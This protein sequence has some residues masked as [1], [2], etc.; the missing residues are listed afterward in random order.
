MWPVL[1]CIDE[2][3]HPASSKFQCRGASGDGHA[4]NE[5]AKMAFQ[6]KSAEVLFGNVDAWPQAG[7]NTADARL[8]AANIRHFGCIFAAAST[9]AFGVAQDPSAATLPRQ[10]WKLLSRFT[11]AG[12]VRKRQRHLGRPI[13]LSQL[14]LRSTDSLSPV[15]QPGTCSLRPITI[16]DDTAAPLQP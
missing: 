16:Q 3:S 7:R 10:K 12:N 4:S 8:N 14:T 1:Y 15:D 9:G 2:N 5:M 6:A 13:P 11:A